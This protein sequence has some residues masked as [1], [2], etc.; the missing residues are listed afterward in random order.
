M[1][2]TYHEDGKDI[3]VEYK[4]DIEPHLRFAEAKRN[5]IS[6][7]ERIGE[8]HHAMRVPQVIVQKIMNETGLNFFEPGHWQEI[9][10][11]LKRDYA[12]AFKTT[13]HNL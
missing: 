12:A 7:S 9:W 1:K 13:P 4:D 2:T 6:R 8:W 5:S 3:L 10:K 11:I